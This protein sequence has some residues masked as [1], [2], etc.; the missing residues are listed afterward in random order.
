MRAVYA[1]LPGV[2]VEPLR[3]SSEDISGHRLLAMMKIDD[4]NREYL[5][6]SFTLKLLLKNMSITD[7]P[8]YMQSIMAILRSMESFDYD[9]FRKELAAQ[10]FN[11]D[12]K[13]ALNLRL[14]LLDSCLKGG[15]SN[16]R[17]GS[18]FKPGTLTI[19]EY[20]ATI[21]LCVLHTVDV[22]TFSLS[23]QFMDGASACGFFE[24]ILGLFVEADLGAGKLVGT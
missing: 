18:H 7:M 1:G 14:A 5:V 6:W 17:V 2:R 21:G 16:N 24:L 8:L 20:V 4:S 11:P 10:A 9:A 22:S 12:Q 23:S 15:N 19:I 13:S 3:F